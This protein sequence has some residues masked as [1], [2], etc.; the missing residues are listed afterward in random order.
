MFKPDL[1]SDN[2]VH[3][4]KS[5]EDH[6]DLVSSVIKS[7]YS[8][9]DASVAEVYQS[10]AIELNSNNYKLELD[11]QVYVLKKIK[12]DVSVKS[13]KIA[14]ANVVNMLVSQ[15]VKLPEVLPTD[16]SDLIAEYMGDFWCLMPYLDGRYYSGKI[17][18]FYSVV[19]GMVDLCQELASLECERI[20]SVKGISFFSD[21]SSEIFCSYLNNKA[22]L[23][24]LFGENAT[25]I[26]LEMR[27]DIKAA[28]DDLAIYHK[29]HNC[30]SLAHIDV[31]PH[32]VLVQSGSLISLLD[33]ESILWTDA[34][35]AFLFSVFKLARQAVVNNDLSSIQEALNSVISRA[36]NRGVV[37]GL[38][39]E[40]LKLLT[41]FEVIRRLLL[42][43]DLSLNQG[44]NDWNH[45]LPIQLLSLGE[46]DVLYSGYPE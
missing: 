40:R 32:N 16:S 38:S 28:I 24:S 43:L 23:L 18:E 19:D 8:H 14:Q 12:G 17:R 30:V 45:V 25:E 41:K 31:H 42:I 7:A 3:F 34:E 21:K 6:F 35:T 10:G 5:D 27:D 2:E 39:K 46:I 9:F 1:F 33:F 11:A 4:F 29:E 15:G 44:V 22:Q 37:L 26:L 36:G 13:E 20:G